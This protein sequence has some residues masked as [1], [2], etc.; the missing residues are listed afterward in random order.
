MD[1]GKHADPVHADS[2]PANYFDSEGCAAL[3]RTLSRISQTR[4]QELPTNDQSSGLGTLV[5]DGAN[6]EKF[7]FEDR[8]RTALDRMD[9]EGIKKR[10]LGVGFVVRISACIFVQIA[11]ND[12][13]T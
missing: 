7:D 9:E 1:T 4:E 8:L 5:E 6:E 12:N 2:V 10:E 13:R 3:D 11:E